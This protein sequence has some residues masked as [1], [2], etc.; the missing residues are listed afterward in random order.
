MKVSYADLVRATNG[1]SSDNLVGTGSFG[2]VYKGMLDDDGSDGLQVVAVKVL[3]LQLREASRGFMSECETLK[4]VRHRNLVK[5]LTV[6]SSVDFR[7]NDFKAVVFDFMA[8]GSLDDWLNPKENQ[9]FQSKNL[10]FAQRLNIAIDVASALEYLHCQCETPIVHCDLKPSNILLDS[11]ITA[12]VSDFGLAKLLKETTSKSSL[13]STGSIGLKGTIG[14]IAPEYGMMN[15]TSVQG[16][17]YSFGILLLEMFTAKRPTD[18]MFKEGES[19]RKFVELAFPNRILDI[20]DA[21]MFLEEDEDASDNSNR[22]NVPRVLD[23]LASVF[24]IGIECSSELPAD[25]MKIGE[26][27]SGLHKLRYAFIQKG[28]NPLRPIV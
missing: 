19:L 16:D 10:S 18:P 11:N 9:Q 8:N 24:R 17:V 27:I 23:C 6:C 12:H 26:V 13:G 14:Y 25:R 21:R 15:K 20:A 1:F 28:S 3:N 4:N 7:G 2:M 22:L 5:I